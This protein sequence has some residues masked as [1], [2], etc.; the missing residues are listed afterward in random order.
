MKYFMNGKKVLIA[1]KNN[2]GNCF[3]TRKAF[4]ENETF[5]IWL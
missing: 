4:I 5:K 1:Q 2:E 3:K